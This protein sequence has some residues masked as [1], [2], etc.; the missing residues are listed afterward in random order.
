MV[1]N[2]D[3]WTIT[4]IAR[5]RRPRPRPHRV[6]LPPDYVPAHDELGYATT[7]HATQGRTVDHSLLLL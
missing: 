2:R 5:R 4:A 7:A 3:Q 1:R 6:T